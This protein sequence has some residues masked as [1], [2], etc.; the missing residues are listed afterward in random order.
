VLAGRNI[1]IEA[2]ALGRVELTGWVDEA[3]EI[4]YALTLVRGV[5]QVRGVT[6]QLAVQPRAVG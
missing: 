4:D 2:D 3:S 6:N 5:P 1:D